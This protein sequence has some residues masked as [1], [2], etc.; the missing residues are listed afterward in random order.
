[1]V[2]ARLHLHDERAERSATRNFADKVLRK[3]ELCAIM[4][5]ESPPSKQINIA[6]KS[7]LKL[8][9]VM[10]GIVRYIKNLP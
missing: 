10:E 4:S 9:A 6:F 7:Y 3:D 5:R 8:L 2:L 1:M